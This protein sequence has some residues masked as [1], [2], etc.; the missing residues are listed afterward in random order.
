M[1]VACMYDVQS[2]FC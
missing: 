2:V 1:K